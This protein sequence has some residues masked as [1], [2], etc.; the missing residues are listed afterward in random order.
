MPDAQR[1]CRHAIDEFVDWYCSEPR[2][3]FNKTVVIRCRMYPVTNMVVSLGS[4]PPFSQSVNITQNI[5]L[6]TP[7]NSPPGVGAALSVID[8][9]FTNGHVLSYNFNVQHEIWGTLF[10]VAYVGSQGR[11]LRLIGDLNQGIGV[12]APS[13]R[14]HPSAPP[15]HPSPTRPAAR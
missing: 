3:S 14:S 2:H 7:F 10:Q 8:P 13:L 4:N 12:S 1:G 6:A 9:N 15:A 11:H 5:T